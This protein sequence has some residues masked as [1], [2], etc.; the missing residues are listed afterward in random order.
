MRSY[1]GVRGLQ[2]KRDFSV[3][4]IDFV[5]QLAALTAGK[6][7]LAFMTIPF[8]IPAIKAGKVRTLFTMKE[9]MGGAS[10]LSVMCLRAP[11]IAEHRAALVDF[12]EDTQR[13][14]RWFLDPNNRGA[15]LDIVSRFTK[16]PASAYSDWLF[17]KEDDYHDVDARVDLAVMQRD[18]ETMRKTDL[19]KIDI[20]VRKYA[21]LSL[22]EEA[23]HRL[24]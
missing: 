17:T 1:L 15:V 23:A 10:E 13:A 14:M 18:I 22:V 19:L 12:F 4:E 5:N 21:D 9:A 20:D 3:V 7:D 2:D 6:T 24:H 11:F 16:Q 8:S